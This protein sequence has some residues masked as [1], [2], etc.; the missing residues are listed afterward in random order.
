MI[1][2]HSVV[3]ESALDLLGLPH[4]DLRSPLFLGHEGTDQVVHAG[5]A[6]IVVDLQ[7][8]LEVVSACVRAIRCV[9][10]CACA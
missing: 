1:N 8:P 9:Q 10:V 2:S 7:H 3:G 4:T 5:A 6:H